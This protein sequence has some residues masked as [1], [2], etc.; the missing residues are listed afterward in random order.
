MHEAFLRHHDQ[1]NLDLLQQVLT[2]MGRTDLIGNGP[3][4]LI[5]PPKRRS[6]D[7]HGRRPASNTGGRPPAKMSSR[8]PP[9]KAQRQKAYG[10]HWDS[11]KPPS[12]GTNKNSGVGKS[13]DIS[14]SG[15]VKSGG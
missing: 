15:G 8:R 11:G 3:N 5:L 1:E 6:Q 10:G 4:Q 14:K 12:S 7:R 2:T 9:Q 13:S